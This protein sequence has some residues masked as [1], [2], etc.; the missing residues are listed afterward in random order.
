VSGELR[1]SLSVA[2][3]AKL[4]GVEV[5]QLYADDPATGMM[6]LVQPLIGFAR[7]GPGAPQAKRRGLGGDTRSAMIGGAVLREQRV[8]SDF[9]DRSSTRL[10]ESMQSD[11]AG[12]VCRD[13][14][15]SEL[16]DVD[17]GSNALLQFPLARK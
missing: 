1:A 11:Y 15:A 4:R 14:W 12:C 13:Q 16:Y 7:G 8:P 3:T 17:P 2:N 9:M 6:L 5:V 10:G